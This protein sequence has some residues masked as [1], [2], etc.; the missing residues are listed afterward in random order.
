MTAHFKSSGSKKKGPL[1]R[2]PVFS[3]P[4]RIRSR[5]VALFAVTLISTFLLWGVALGLQIAKV[6]NVDFDFA[7]F[8]APL[9][10]PLFKVTAKALTLSVQG[11]DENFT[12]SPSPLGKNALSNCNG[13]RGRRDALTQGSRDIFAFLPIEPIWSY[14]SLEAHCAQID[15]LV[16]AWYEISGLERPV[17][18]LGTKFEYGDRIQKLI[19]SNRDDFAL[20]PSI[21]LPEFSSIEDV[22]ALVGTAKLRQSLVDEVINIAVANDLD[23]ICLDTSGF[24]SETVGYSADIL[25]RLK[26]GFAGLNLKTCSVMDFDN[27][28]WM[29]TTLVAASD[30]VV[31]T[32][33][34]EP[35]AGSFP[36]P[37]A[38]Q[39]W[40]VES[41][42]FVAERVP[43]D[44]LV[45]A[46]G[47]G[48]Y[49]WESGQVE[50]VRSDYTSIISQTVLDEGQVLYFDTDLNSQAIRVDREKRRHVSWFL[51]AA[52]FHNQLRA[53]EGYG[54]AGV[55][56][57]TIGREDPGVWDVLALQSESF[58][59]LKD[60]LA[61]V[62]VADGVR[63]F[64]E[65]SFYHLSS[66]A[67]LG[68]R[69][70]AGDQ[71]DGLIHAQ[72]YAV[73]PMP[74]LIERFGEPSGNQ[75]TLT[76]DD[77]PD[78][79]FTAKVLD[80]LKDKGVKAT[81]FVVGQ[82]IA[83]APK[84]LKR[85][86][87]EGHIVGSHSFFHPKLEEVSPSRVRLELNSVQRIV[88]G[89]TGHRM[90]LYRTPFGKSQGPDTAEFV[91]PIRVATSLGYIEMSSDV[92]T[93][94]WTNNSAEDIREHVREGAHRG[95][96]V[97]ML[98]DAGG[99]RSAT[100]N[101]LGPMI[102]EMRAEGYEFVSATEILGL[103]VSDLMPLDDSFEAQLHGMSFN[104][105]TM[106]KSAFITIFWLTVVLG[107]LRSL[108]I[109]FLALTRRPIGPRDPAYE[110]LVTV[111]VAAYNEATVIEASIKTIL[112]SDYSNLQVLVI[113][114]GSKDS[115]GNVVRSAFKKDRRV[116]V[117]RQKNGGKWRALNAAYRYVSTDIVVA[118]DADTVLRKDAIRKLVARF[119]DPKVGAVAGNVKVGNRLNLLTRLQAVEYITAQNLERRA[120][121]KINGMLVV[122]GAIGAWR[123]AAVKEAG[124]YSGD[125][126]AEDADLTVSIQRCG[127]SVC[128]VEDAISVTEAPATLVPF[129][130]QRLRWTL[131]MMQMAWKHRACYTEKRTIGLVSLTDLQIFGVL[132]AL[133]APIADLVLITTVGVAI[134][135]FLAG[136]P[137]LDPNAS[138]ILLA[139]Y[140]LLPLM[141]IILAVTA[142]RLDRRNDGSETY[143]QLWV[144]PF[145]RIFYRQML[146][147]TVY[148]SVLRALT[149]RLAKWGT[150]KRMGTV[151]L[152]QWT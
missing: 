73:L 152:S 26:V 42:D 109:L 115:T 113:D 98:H 100:V 27:E 22:E 10:E 38:P 34:R 76:F 78:P 85:I 2:L 83:L 53:L 89:L 23:G 87:R 19:N 50:P 46:L 94:D 9:S 4:A 82:N 111:V 17:L 112:A 25:Q 101:A 117:H 1:E 3:D 51:D 80:V 127:Y 121:D 131:G 11:L 68:R 116:K 56:V 63:Y 39:Q 20:M 84:V 147:F 126:L 71:G 75:I 139:G 88:A 54:L 133:F 79:V 45:F 119:S 144:I 15:V 55:A 28:F 81:F 136:R 59:T 12:E 118:I 135:E 44:K 47:T 130:K 36:A 108:T 151:K 95:N 114:D 37:I 7:P 58:A 70:F 24:P 14:T 105:L 90:A 66:E 57:W 35:F 16:P 52:S 96:R 140:I 104:F 74:I 6:E 91:Q 77:G 61:T 93:Y 149:G 86:V 122:P 69:S 129:L 29:D 145:Q 41:A 33:I 65:G 43:S 62:S 67:V 138:Y 128:F 48:G 102:D 49:D 143:S 132:F 32:M 125:T 8:A 134:K 30:R 110:P 72:D 148:R 18:N 31:I 141:D 146:Y 40:F 103:K 106:A 64:G 99:D 13:Q 21:S 142:V 107:I 124:G 150:L 123:V 120:F 92:V 60:R 5:R 137:P 97:V